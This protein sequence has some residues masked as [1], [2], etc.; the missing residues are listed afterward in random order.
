MPQSG[1]GTSSGLSMYSITAAGPVRPDRADRLRRAAVFG[2]DRF[3]VRGRASRC[4]L[5]RCVATVLRAIPTTPRRSG[6][7]EGQVQHIRYFR[8]HARL[9]TPLCSSPRLSR[10]IG[11]TAKRACPSAEQPNTFSSAPTPPCAP[12]PTS[13]TSAAGR[14]SRSV[15]PLATWNAPLLRI[16][17]TADPKPTAER[18]RFGDRTSWTNC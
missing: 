5:S 6:R 4:R 8:G 2:S 9:T 18:S 1:S 10:L 15:Q 16:T 11:S 3:L 17:P 14:Q 13:A 12:P 7:L